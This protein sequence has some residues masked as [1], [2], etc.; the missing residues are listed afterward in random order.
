MKKTLTRD[1]EILSEEHY[2]IDRVTYLPRLYEGTKLGQSFETVYHGIRFE[3]E[4]TLDFFELPE[5]VEIKTATNWEEFSKVMQEINEIQYPPPKMETMEELNVRLAARRAKILA[6]Y[7]TVEEEVARIQ[8]ERAAAKQAEIAGFV[9]QQEEVKRKDSRR[10]TF[11][12]MTI[13]VIVLAWIVY[14]IRKQYVGKQS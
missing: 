4:L 12:L 3:P 8:S 11:V 5:G 14:R 6:S 7:P 2:I 10:R 1:G 13:N 9:K